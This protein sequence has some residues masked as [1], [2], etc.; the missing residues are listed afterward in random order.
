MKQILKNR[1]DFFIFLD[2]DGVLNSEEW[3]LSFPKGTFFLI[4]DIDPKLVKNLQY[5]M[6]EINKEHRVVICVSSSWRSQMAKVGYVLGRAGL[7]YNEMW[8]KTE[9]TF[10]DRGREILDFIDKMKSRG[11]KMNK[12]L[13]IDDESQDIVNYIPE[14]FFLKTHYKTGLTREIVEQWLSKGVLK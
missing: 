5:L 12:Y 11:E 14:D 4:D 7:E 9:H 1:E 6:D 2:I 13:V 3:V 8:Y 10:G